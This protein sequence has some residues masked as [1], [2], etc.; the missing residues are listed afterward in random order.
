MDARQRLSAAGLRRTA[1]RVLVTERMVAE[2]RPLT[3]AGICEALPELDRVTVYRTLASLEG[4]G[5]AHKVQGLDGAWRYCIDDSEISGCPGGHPHL[6]CT[7]CGAMACLLG[8]G[9]PWVAVPEGFAVQGKQL[10]VHGI[11]A[12]CAAAGAR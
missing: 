7:R 8:Q 2:G 3:P 5:L 1:A 12:S 6:L 4:A 9:L 10:V 11:C